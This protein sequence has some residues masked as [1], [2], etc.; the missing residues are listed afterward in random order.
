[1]YTYT[2]I[3][4]TIISLIKKFVDIC[5]KYLISFRFIKLKIFVF[6]E[7]NLPTSST[8]LDTGD[9]RVKCISSNYKKPKSRLLRA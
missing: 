3:H 5:Y 6:I 4:T 9:M 2:H 7:K 8:R 1:M